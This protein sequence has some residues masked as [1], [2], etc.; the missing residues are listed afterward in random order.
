MMGEVP[1]LSEEEIAV[2]AAQRPAHPVRPVTVE[3]L[4]VEQ[5]VT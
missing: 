1:A 2:I 3:Y 5:L 4:N